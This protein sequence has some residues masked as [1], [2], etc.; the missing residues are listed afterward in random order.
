MDQVNQRPP[1]DRARALGPAIAAADEI[2]ATQ[3]IPEPL[4]T[5]LYDAGLWRL[6]LPRS[7]GGEEAHPS[8]YLEALMEIA[9]HDGSVGWNMFVANSSLLLAPFIPLESAQ[10]IWGDPRAV[11]CWGPPNACRLK[12]EPGGY[13]VDGEWDFASGSRQATWAGAHA[14][15][16]EPDGS[17]RLNDH[18][19]PLI[20]SVLFPV[21]H[22]EFL[23][24]WNPI[25]MK[26]TASDSYR[27]KDLFVP[28]TF[29]GTRE[30]PAL[31]R[32]RGPLYAF[33]M[34]GLY[35]VGVAGVA[36]GI[37]RAM[38]AAFSDLAQTKAPRGRPRLAD[39]AAT[40]S[41]YARAEAKLGAGQAYLASILNDV[42]ERAND[43]APIGIEDRAMVRLGCSTA[44]QN[45]VEV[46]D[47]VHRAA[48]VSAIFPGSPFER[49]FRDIHTLSQ[50]I[51]S[52][53][54]HFEAVGQVLLGNP[55]QVFF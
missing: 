13:R 15:V 31:R 28:E 44:I 25:G 5:D 14:Q 39:D 17:L 40:Q 18:G 34:Q 22:A 29:S 20:R 27:V 53:P 2:E 35:A 21:A 3:T 30:E 38:L 12:A 6:F 45:A 50:Q 8:A 10:A 37:A 54:A 36:L 24:K 42:Y 33:T 4:L 43:I 51:Q 26:G 55:P 23:D 52:R 16:E 11:I 41:D 32:D 49:R 47:W 7:L 19:K 9:S 1:V 48:G 46:A